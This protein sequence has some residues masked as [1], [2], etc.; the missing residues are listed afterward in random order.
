MP[1]LIAEQLRA[2]AVKCSRLA[3]ESSDRGT[4]N[5]LEGVSAQLAEK[6]Q[7]LDELFTLI[8]KAS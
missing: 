2:L 8:D 4:A 7:R 3:R 1:H 6:A 5:Q